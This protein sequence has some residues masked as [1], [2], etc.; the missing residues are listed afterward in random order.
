M[1][2]GLKGK[3]RED[4]AGRGG[5][6]ISGTS[7]YPENDSGTGR[8]GKIVGYQRG[9]EQKATAESNRLHRRRLAFNLS[10]VSLLQL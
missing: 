7:G 3:K 9:T 5:S 10:S 4:A 2:R 6:M 8:R 1:L